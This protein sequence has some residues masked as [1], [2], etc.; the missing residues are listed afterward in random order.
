MTESEVVELTDGE[1]SYAY[2]V[3]AVRVAKHIPRRYVPV[4]S[5]RDRVPWVQRFLYTH[6]EHAVGESVLNKH[7][8]LFWDPEEGRGRHFRGGHVHGYYVRMTSHHGRDLWAFSSDP[9][10]AVLVLI[11]GHINQLR[12]RVHG[13]TYAKEAKYDYFAT[14]QREDVKHDDVMYRLPDYFLN[15]MKNLPAPGDPHA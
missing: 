2:Q 5:I 1:L 8:G 11:S 10:E 6:V 14:E 13:W 3:G 9:D 4:D 7:L 12:Y 15:S